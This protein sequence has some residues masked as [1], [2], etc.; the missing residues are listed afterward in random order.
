M[1]ER[2]D[3]IQLE[4][5]LVE[6]GERL[7]YPRPTRMA[8][9][10]RARL[11]E[12]RR[13]ARWLLGRVG[14]APAAVTAALLLIVIALALPGV[15]AAATEFLRLRGIDIFPSA[16]IAPR[17]S[18]SPTITFPGERVSLDE[19]RRR[20]HFAIKTPVDA[21]L[22]EPDEVRVDVAGTN[23]RVTLVYAR[24]VSI[25][26]SPEA[27]V[28]AVVVEF[29]GHVDA[30]LFGKAVGTG[31]RLDSVNVDGAPG[32]WLEGQP[33]LFFWRDNAGGIQ[34]ETLRLAGNTLIWERDGVTY[35]LEAQVGRDDALRI[36]A[37]FR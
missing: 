1:A 17:P 19:A 18:A 12:P 27:G 23:E 13:R 32:Y 10:V 22:G 3:D 7:D 26:V 15:R 34:Q 20:V 9:A 4:A 37:S 14:L 16:S 33:H 6:I 25:P 30:T 31:T 11:R 21:R 29:Q 24:R 36:A 8:D 35:R 2:L 5:T 28:S